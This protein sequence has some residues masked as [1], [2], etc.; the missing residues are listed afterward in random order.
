MAVFSSASIQKCHDGTKGLSGYDS[1]QTRIMGRGQEEWQNRNID[2]GHTHAIELVYNR[3]A[4]SDRPGAVRDSVMARIREAQG[5][6]T[7]RKD[8][9]CVCSSSPRCPTTAA[10]A[11]LSAS[12]SRGL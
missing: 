2:K 4:E 11:R 12:V 7:I 10:A 5:D 9:V 8:A 1:E 6:K 3:A